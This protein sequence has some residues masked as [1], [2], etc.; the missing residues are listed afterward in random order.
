MFMSFP[1]PTIVKSLT[2]SRSG[3]RKCLISFPGPVRRQQCQLLLASGRKLSYWLSLNNPGLMNLC[4]DK[5]QPGGVGALDL[6]A[7]HLQAPIHLVPEWAWREKGPPLSSQLT[8][9]AVCQSRTGGTDIFSNCQ[10]INQAEKAVFP[11]HVPS[12]RRGSVIDSGA[13]LAS[14]RRG[15]WPWL[16][17]IYWVHGSE[18]VAWCLWVSILSQKNEDNDSS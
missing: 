2:D 9:F 12:G 13:A 14:S 1:L 3:G 10:N 7:W 5:W 11:S 4:C 6:H 17:S 15:F 8:L 16:S 18:Q